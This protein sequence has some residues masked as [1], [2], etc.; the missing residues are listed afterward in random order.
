LRGRGDT[1]RQ[2]VRPA[3]DFLRI[4]H[5]L[6]QTGEEAGG[7]ALADGAARTEQGGPGGHLSRQRNEVVFISAGAMEQQERRRGAIPGRFEVMDKV[8]DGDDSRLDCE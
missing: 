4:E 8:L 3:D 5:S 1:I 2:L 7:T 6:G